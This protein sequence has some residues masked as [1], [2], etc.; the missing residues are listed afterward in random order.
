M[1]V[2]N[3]TSLAKAKKYSASKTNRRLLG[4]AKDADRRI[5]V[6]IV[7]T[8]ETTR[9]KG[10]VQKPFR[11][12]DLSAEQECSL[13]VPSQ[14]HVFLAGHYIGPLFVSTSRSEL[15]L[16]LISASG[17]RLYHAIAIYPLG[18]LNS[19]SSSHLLPHAT[20]VKAPKSFIK[21][22]LGRVVWMMVGI[23]LTPFIFPLWLLYFIPSWLRP[24]PKRTYLQSLMQPWFKTFLYNS[25][26][27]KIQ[28]PA[29][30]KP[31]A[32][33]ERFVLIHPPEK[34]HF[35][36]VLRETDIQPAVIA[37]TWLPAPYQ[38]SPGSEEQTVVLYF[39][40]GAFVMGDGRTAQSAFAANML[41][42]HLKATV[43]SICYRLCSNPNC[44]F[45]AALQDAVSA[46]SHLLSLAIP[47]DHIIIAG[48]SAGA[49]LVIGLLRYIADNPDKLPHPRAAL[50]GSPWLDPHSA[51]DPDSIDK[52][53]NASTDF[54][55]GNFVAWGAH[56]YIPSHI[57][58]ASPYISP[59]NHPFYTD[60]PMWVCVGGLEVLYDDG[61][62]FVD[63][64]KAKGN[65]VKLHVEPFASHSF[66]SAGVVT[67]FTREADHAVKL[68]AEWMR[69]CGGGK[70]GASDSD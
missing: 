23:I 53:R 44:E 7:G 32:E 2:F 14:Q 15:L 26:L 27:M 56:E 16:Y 24:H 58:A 17:C 33:K 3:L 55:P 52:H 37:G 35:Q 48:D 59:L 9:S 8:V 21:T 69:E 38:P 30:L 68:A 63:N 22:P 47:A 54:L 49:N 12:H 25:A 65:R 36:G 61:V 6:S 50:L 66:L 46:Y 20:M 10:Q 45:P 67:R 1:N 5:E 39:H 28:T 31:G 40:G 19:S 13:T 64:M 70:G 34:D 62:T 43:L 57:D 60:T 29:S 41:I 51:L 11:H 4:D 18:L 42:T